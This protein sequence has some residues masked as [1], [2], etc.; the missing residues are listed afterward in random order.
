[1]KKIIITSLLLIACFVAFSQDNK[2]VK[3]FSLVGKSEAQVTE[4]IGKP[5]TK[6]L[7]HR[8]ADSYDGYKYV[9]KTAEYSIAFR[10]GNAFVV[11]A[12]PLV[13]QKFNEDD[14]FDGGVFDIENSSI[15]GVFKPVKGKEKELS[16]FGFSTGLNAYTFYG[17][18]GNVTKAIAF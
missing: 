1:M 6:T 14:L 2:P 3:F 8:G 7:V 11:V 15:S 10:N 9:T 4:L 5:T 13:K 17:T 16:Y 18:N 12:K